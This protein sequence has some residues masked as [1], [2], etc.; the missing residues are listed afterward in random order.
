[1]FLNELLKTIMRPHAESR[2]QT[3][4]DDARGCSRRRCFDRA[5]YLPSHLEFLYETEH[6]YLHVAGFCAFQAFFLRYGIDGP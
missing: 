5:F 1:M 4:C 6:L 2:R 3:V